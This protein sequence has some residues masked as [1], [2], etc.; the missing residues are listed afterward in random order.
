M[1]SVTL[2][3]QMAFSTPSGVKLY[4]R[5]K[6]FQEFYDKHGGYEEGQIP[7]EKTPNYY[8]RPFIPRRI[9]KMDPDAKVI[10]IF[11]DNVRRV[12]SRSDFIKIISCLLII[13]FQSIDPYS[14][15]LASNDWN[16]SLQRFL[17]IKGIQNHKLDAIGSTF[18]QFQVHL[19]Q[20]IDEMKNVLADI[21]TTVSSEERFLEILYRKMLRGERPFQTHGVNPL[22]W[23]LSAGF[24]SVYHKESF[25]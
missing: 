4:L 7:F 8:D 2:E 6:F 23:I 9:L 25:N 14:T 1:K 5:Y 10:I 15:P 3:G 12:L 19:N 17:H 13:I 11:C 16:K 24:Y 21:R 18:D 20:S 22:E